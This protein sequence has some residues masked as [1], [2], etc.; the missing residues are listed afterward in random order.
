MA[1]AILYEYQTGVAAWMD[2]SFVDENYYPKGKKY[3]C[4]NGLK[5]L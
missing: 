4:K 2:E 1:P 3:I 5:K